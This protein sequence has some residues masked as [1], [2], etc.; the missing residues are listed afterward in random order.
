L[1]KKAEKNGDPPEDKAP[2]TIETDLLNLQ[3]R[4]D[5]VEE[6]LHSLRDHLVV[7]RESVI[8]QS[9]SLPFLL[10]QFK[11]LALD[12]AA[13]GKLLRQ[14]EEELGI[15]YNSFQNAIRESS[16]AKEELKLTRKYLDTALKNYRTVREENMELKEKI[17]ELERQLRVKDEIV[18]GMKKAITEI[19]KLLEQTKTPPET[20]SELRR[21]LGEAAAPTPR[22]PTEEEEE[23]EEE[24][25]EE[26]E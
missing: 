24:F 20:I 1:K 4:I 5:Q 2:E 12:L 7:T 17:G 8:L 15:R 9:E 25:E 26:L 19:S 13:Q 18:K 14:I 10:Q 3:Q 6:S 11:R 23:I 22:I 16:R 21:I